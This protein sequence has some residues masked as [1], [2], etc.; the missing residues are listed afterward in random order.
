MGRFCLERTARGDL[1]K[2]DWKICFYSSEHQPK[3]EKVRVAILEFS[4]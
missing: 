1:A 3:P 4:F 2:D